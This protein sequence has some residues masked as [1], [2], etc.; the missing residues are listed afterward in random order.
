MADHAEGYIK[1]AD[2]LAKNKSQIDFYKSMLREK[3]LNSDN[4]MV[5]GFAALLHSGTV[6][7]GKIMSETAWIIKS[8]LDNKLNW[9]HASMTNNYKAAL[10]DGSFGGKIEDF[11]DAVG[12][13]IYKATGD[14]QRQLNQGISG[15]IVGMERLAIMQK[16]QGSVSRT[17]TTGNKHID[18]SV[19]EFLGY[20]NDVHA[21]GNK[22]G[23][24]AFRNSI[25]Q[26]YAPKS[27]LYYNF[28]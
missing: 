17:T 21:Y 23:M 20:W 18:K 8:K 22:L 11:N 13:A 24:E 28:Y 6:H 26:G 25:A 10:A 16:R 15:D 3:L 1:I 19:D 14:I 4:Q 12:K 9:V 2:S 27:L 7:H 5:S